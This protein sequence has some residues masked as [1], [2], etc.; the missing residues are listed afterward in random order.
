MQTAEVHEDDD[1]S[2]EED[3]QTNVFKAAEQEVIT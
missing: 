2:D 1:D 3:I